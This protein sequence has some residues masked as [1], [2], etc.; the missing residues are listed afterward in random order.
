MRKISHS[1]HTKGQALIVVVAVLVMLF[2]ITMAFFVLSQT[3]RTAAI[4][5]LDSLRAQYIAE[6]GV[7]YAQKILGLD[8]QANLIDSLED[9]TFKNF[10]GQD[11]DMDG[12]GINESRWIDL[13][14]NQGNPFGRF[15][16]K[17]SDEASR[18]NINSS[19]NEI[20]TRLF[21]GAAIETSKASEVFSRRP[22]NAKEE[23]SSIL[24]AGDFSRIKDSLTIYSRDLEIDLHKK[25]RVYLNTPQPRLILEACLSA[26]VK[27]SYQK[28]ANLKDASDTDFNQTLLD[29]FSQTL[30]P[31]GILEPGGWSKVASFYEAS[32]GNDTPGKFIW[33][34]LAVEDGEYYCF[35][36]GPGGMDVVAGDPPLFTGEGLMETVKVEGGSLTLTIKPAKSTTS[37]F[38]HIELVSLTPKNGLYRRIITGTEALVINEIM[39]KPSKEILVDSP[40]T[41]EAGYS[42]EWTFTQI[43]P[44]NYYVVV[45]AIAP[46]GLVGD[47]SISSQ[48]GENL[49]DQDY[50]P[51]VVSVDVKGEINLKIKNNSLGES[52]FKGI[53]IFQEPDTEFIEIV[54]LS[55]NRIDLSNF[56]VEVYTTT[57]ELVSGWPAH[58]LANTRIE[59]YQHLVLAVD[60]NDASPTPNN[61]QGNRISFYGVYNTNAVG[62]VFDEA[63]GTIS[64]E[65]DLLPDSGGRVILKDALGERIDAIEYQALQISDFTSLE[66]PDPSQK[67]DA[68]GNG[69]FDGWYLSQGE[70][71]CT[72]GLPNENPGM[73][74]RNENGDLIKHN[75]SEVTVFNYSLAGL[76]EV[77]QLS[78]G[79]NWDKFS[80]QDIA[81]MAD[82]FAY[83]VIDLDM[84]GHEKE[85]GTDTSGI[86]EFTG[87]AQGNYL[88]S[89]SSNNTGLQGKEIQVSIKTDVTSDFTDLQPLLF[90][91]GFA[92]YGSVNI[93]ES[94]LVLQI[95]IVTESA[96][97]KA[98]L[99][100]IQL[101]PVFSV[102]GRVNINTAKPEILRSIFVFE[103]LVNSVVINRPIGA[104]GS[105]FLGVGDLFL[106][107]SGFV[108]FH[109]NLTVK[110]D[111]YEIKS[112]GD[113]LQQ[114][115]SIAY[116]TIR[117]I[118]ERAE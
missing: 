94:S 39:V 108:P 33:S 10:E 91:Q 48:T 88:L 86:W 78:S 60:N 28:A 27:D 9:L 54:N 12:D 101:E 92:F 45:E 38:S 47:V 14:D 76:A 64:K 79:Q 105:R 62:L 73:Y 17:I 99:Q 58:I 7:A 36:Y 70:D 109:K 11:V 50:F 97:D 41:I 8:K 16:V 89:I 4:R 13:A 85:G 100:K 110:S 95:K 49:R 57:G 65:N 37:R 26:G 66:R 23:I 56:S 46:G 31:T 103:S 106:L 71:L 51:R 74:T 104:K 35:L 29:K 34:N 5:H 43:K 67:F 52:S 44:G 81:L 69:Y 90:M 107:D 6:A 55:P 2:V 15:S 96:E 32:P 77:E 98:G 25:R 30:S 1:N 68:D 22:F 116:Q 111:V 61:L 21:S 84:A 87:V 112:R 19:S 118:L 63:S 72:P 59:P 102:P 24:G 113:F 40:A 80:L 114:G 117:T 93:P 3:E 75:I 83:D 115:K 82:R 42:K 18:I 20:L 53:K